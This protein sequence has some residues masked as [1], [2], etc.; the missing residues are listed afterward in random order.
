MYIGHATTLQLQT[1]LM[2]R[3]TICTL[4]RYHLSPF[5]QTAH[6]GTFKPATFNTDFKERRIRKLPFCQ[7]SALPKMISETGL[8]ALSSSPVYL[9]HLLQTHHLLETLHECPICQHSRSD[10]V[11]HIFPRLN[12]S[13]F[14]LQVGSVR[15]RSEFQVK[16]SETQVNVA[17]TSR[18]YSGLSLR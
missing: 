2:V 14:M 17:G 6:A 11:T 12:K 18:L 16:H 15:S 7:R 1:I 3:M 9:L 10:P 8:R 5:Q 4:S 13:K